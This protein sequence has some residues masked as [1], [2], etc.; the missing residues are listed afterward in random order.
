MGLETVS[1]DGSYTTSLVNI[2][3]KSFLEENPSDN[4]P[5]FVAAKFVKADANDIP[6]KPTNLQWT[7]NADHNWVLSWDN[8]AGADQYRCEIN[9]EMGT[10]LDVKITDTNKLVLSADDTTGGILYAY[11]PCLT[12]VIVSAVKNKVRS[13]EAVSDNLHNL[14]QELTNDDTHHWYACGICGYSYDPVKEAHS[15]GEW[16]I[17]TEATE[18]ADGTK[19]RECTVCGYVQYADID[20]TDPAHTHNLDT[21]Y[22]SDAAGHWH[23][24]SGCDEKADLAAHSYGDWQIT[25]PATAE[26][27]GKKERVC[28]VCGYVQEGTVIYEEED[29]TPGDIFNATKPENNALCA[30]LELTDEDI[31]NKIPLTPEELEA[32]ENGADLTVYMVVIDYSGNVADEDKALAESVLTGGMQ[33]GMYIDVSLY[34][35]VGDD[36]P[37]PVTKTNSDL[38]ITFEMPGKL[39]NSDNNVTRKYSIIRVHGGNAAILDCAYD[40]QTAKGSFNTSRFSTYAIAYTDTA[41]EAPV[42]KYPINNPTN[43]IVK[44]DKTEAAQGERVSV[45]VMPGYIAHIFGNNGNETAVISGTGSFIMPVGG[46]KITVEYPINLALTWQNSYIY[47]YDSD[48]DYITVNR[49]RKQGTINVDLGKKYAGRSFVIY[50]GKKSTKVKV[51][52]GVLDANGKIT[53]DTEDGMNYTLVVED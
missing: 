36:A 1:A 49:T 8:V 25:V 27:N 43:G 50:E 12:K 34:K 7:M 19:Y 38:K 17:D 47:S 35:K 24:C 14:H 11:A 44:T 13:E 37:K 52:E 29:N 26:A 40:D 39:I 33:M 51:T 45:S 42:T 15:F 18:T 20:P 6:A 28:S 4:V 41:L 16:M 21:E 22:S 31:K 30:D 23:A 5:H 46:V 48:M 32:I 10:P 3:K 53:L 2:P 9:A